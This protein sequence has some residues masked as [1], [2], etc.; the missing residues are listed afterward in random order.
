MQ[1]E[2]V[3]QGCEAPRGKARTAVLGGDDDDTRWEAVASGLAQR[4]LQRLCERKMAKVVHGPR[5]LD[6]VG[7]LS[8][9]SAAQKWHDGGGHQARAAHE[10][11]QPA[12]RLE[13]KQR[14]R[15]GTHGGD[16]REI[17]ED[18]G[19]AAAEARAVGT[20]LHGE[21]G[22][23]RGGGVAGAEQHGEP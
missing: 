12:R 9:A 6:A 4:R 8:V 23:V 7:R 11:V 21:G 2:W 18:W 3:G 17:E 22:L 14:A 16:R 19:Y 15:G 1:V 20:P 10:H 13:G 5:A